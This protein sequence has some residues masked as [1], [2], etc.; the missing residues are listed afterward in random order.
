MKPT[1]KWG[2]SVSMNGADDNRCHHASVLTGLP[3]SYVR[4]V[5]FMLFQ[6]GLNWNYVWYTTKFPSFS[7]PVKHVIFHARISNVSFYIYDVFLCNT[8]KIF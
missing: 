5:C 3:S 4:N 8:N 6:V 2:I 1:C 7:L